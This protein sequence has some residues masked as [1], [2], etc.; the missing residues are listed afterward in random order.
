[1]PSVVSNPRGSRLHPTFFADAGAINGGAGKGVLAG[2]V[3][4]AVH[5]VGVGRAVAG[6]MLPL[7]TQ[8]DNEGVGGSVQISHPEA[9][10]RNILC[11]F[12]DNRLSITK[13]SL[14]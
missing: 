1:M 4:G 11:C 10:S 2:A 14:L 12:K 7:Q 3:H 8:G 6:A 9:S 5:P 13:L